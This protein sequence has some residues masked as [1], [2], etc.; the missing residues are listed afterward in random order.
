MTLDHRVPGCQLCN[1]GACLD[2]L[3]ICTEEPD[4]SSCASNYQGDGTNCFDGDN[5]SVPDIGETNSYCTPSPP[6]T[7]GTDP[8]NPDGDGQLDGND[9]NPCIHD[10]GGQCNNNGV[11]D[12]LETDIDCGGPDCQACPDGANCFGNGDCLSQNCIDG[13]C[14][15][16]ATG[17]CSDLQCNGQ[18]EN[19]HNCSQ[20]CGPC[21]TGDCC[22][23][24]LGQA[25][26]SD[27]VITE[28]VC[29]L[30]PFCCETEWDNICVG[31]ANDDCGAGCSGGNPCGNGTCEPGEDEFSCPSDC[32]INGV[33]NDGVCNVLTEDPVCCTVD[34]FCTDGVCSPGFEDPGNC[35]QDCQGGPPV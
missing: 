5:D 18:V 3:G 7:I 8:K 11:L 12:E 13:V 33:C 19:C 28:C 35:P 25:S 21:G 6:G 30:D 20:D 22:T 29:A 23:E 2:N 27:Q 1:S 10:G 31:I 9:P 4:A 15:P 24:T 32:S 17:F 34:C 14:F 16:P 26:C